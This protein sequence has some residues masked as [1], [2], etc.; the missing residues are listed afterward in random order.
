MFLFFSRAKSEEARYLSNFTL[1][2]TGG[3]EIDHNVFPT[4]ND[5][6]KGKIFPSIE[7]AFQGYKLAISNASESLIDKIIESRDMRVVKQMGARK[8]FETENL[9]LDTRYWNEISISLMSH[10]VRQRLH[11]DKRFREIIKFLVENNITMYHFSREGAKSLWGGYFKKDTGVWVGQ[12]ML[13]K[14]LKEQY[15]LI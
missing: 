7:H 3:I 13:G 4:T 5:I 1:I 6:L 12:N 14:I 9:K 8:F 15:L 11:V 10:L 2:Q